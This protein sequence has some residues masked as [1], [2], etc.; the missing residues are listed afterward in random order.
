TDEFKFSEVRHPIQKSSV[1]RGPE[2]FI[3]EDHTTPII[4]M[5]LFYPGGKLAE[6]KDNAGITSL[7]L[8]WLLKGSKSSPPE[9]LNR[10]LEIFGDTLGT[11]LARYFVRNFSGSRYQ[12]ARLPESFAKALEKRQVLEET[13]NNSQSVVMLGFQAPP[14]GDDDSYPI[15]LMELLFDGMGG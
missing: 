10:Q 6:K 8:H 9:A 1:W 7:L 3:K 4:H 15:R 13:W 2:L 14:E 5:G 12:D 11:S